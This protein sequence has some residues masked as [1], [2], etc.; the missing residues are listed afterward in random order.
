MHSNNF[1]GGGD[2]LPRSNGQILILL[3]VGR[4]CGHPYFQVISGCPLY[5]WHPPS[6]MEQCSAASSRDSRKTQQWDF[7]AQAQAGTAADWK[8]LSS[9]GEMRERE[10]NLTTKLAGIITGM[11][12]YRTGSERTGFRFFP[13]RWPGVCS[14]GKSCWL[15]AFHLM[16]WFQILQLGFS[17]GLF[18]CITLFC[19]H[20]DVFWG[21]GKKSQRFW[22][23]HILHEE[24]MEWRRKLLKL[25]D[26]LSHVKA[27]LYGCSRDKITPFIPQEPGITLPGWGWQ[28]AGF[29][30][31]D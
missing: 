3:E 24:S 16:F 25:A 9:L 8:E 31:L 26:C 4:D 11:R 5:P 12:N 23:L 22:C 30:L 17:G 13:S 2:F 10:L 15:L 21:R 27:L 19:N 14:S 6:L 28:T 20:W 29:S 7:L 18:L 1:W